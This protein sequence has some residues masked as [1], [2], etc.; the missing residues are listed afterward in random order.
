MIPECVLPFLKSYVTGK[1]ADKIVQELSKKAGAYVYN[2]DRFEKLLG[3]ITRN[4]RQTKLAAQ[5]DAIRSDLLSKHYL[6]ETDILAVSPESTVGYKH[7][8]VFFGQNGI[9]E[10]HAEKAETYSVQK[11][12]QMDRFKDWVEEYRVRKGDRRPFPGSTVRVSYWDGKGR[13]GLSQADYIDQFVTNQKE[14][15]D[16]PINDILRNSGIDWPNSMDGKTLRDLNSRNQALAKFED[17]VLSN[18]IGICA[19][20]LT[21]DGMLILPKRNQAVHVQKGYEATSISGVLEWS[22]GLFPEP[23]GEIKTQLERKEG[24]SEILLRKVESHIPLAFAR[25]LERAGKPQ[26]FSLVFT[27]MRLGEFEKLWS[28]S[29]YPKEEYDCI[30]W[31]RVFDPGEI[32]NDPD[33]AIQNIGR[34]LMAASSAHAEIRVGKTPMVLAEEARASMIYAAWFFEEMKRDSFPKAWLN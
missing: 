16:V 22:E 27:N 13:M 8:G 28:E 31:I 17:S 19:S 29:D 21:K 6:K 11:A 24:G 33:T 20:V 32:K 23:F 18:T 3:M 5:R 9:K 30:R 2:G 25:E 15:V 10:I 12:L 14:I 34:R 7:L 1:I 4:R 26:F